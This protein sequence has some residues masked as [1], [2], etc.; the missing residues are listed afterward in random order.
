MSSPARVTIRNVRAALDWSSILVFN[1]DDKCCISRGGHMEVR[2]MLTRVNSECSNVT[3]MLPTYG[4]GAWSRVEPWMVH[5][6]HPRAKTISL[7]R[8]LS[9]NSF[10]VVAR[11]ADAHNPGDV[12]PADEANLMLPVEILRQCVIMLAHE[13]YNVPLSA[14]FAMKDISVDFRNFDTHTI[15][16]KAISVRLTFSIRRGAEGRVTGMTVEVRFYCAGRRIGSGTGTVLILSHETYQQ[17]RNEAPT[18]EFISKAKRTSPGRVG[19][20]RSE[21][22]LLGE[23]ERTLVVDTRHQG[24]YDHPVDHIPGMV[25]LE[26]A[27]QMMT[28]TIDC[29]CSNFTAVYCQF[30]AYAEL[31]KEVHMEAIPITEDSSRIVLRQ[32]DRTIAVVEFAIGMSEPD[33]T[34]HTR[35]SSV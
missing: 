19:R 32:R 27:W 21:D 16:G 4:K 25:I 20:S 5:K 15:H 18:R 2:S 22:V 12:A 11:W 33:N 13:A 23:D 24:F 10:E 9:H 14:A 31:G 1:T 3:N 28:A 29:R 6:R 30:L 34:L 26:A 35:G 8:S 17:V 7:W